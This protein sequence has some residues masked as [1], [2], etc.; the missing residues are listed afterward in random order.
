MAKYVELS[1]LAK[2][3]SK[4]EL[5]S[6]LNNHNGVNGNLIIN[7]IEKNKVVLEIKDYFINEI[8]DDLEDAA[9]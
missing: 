8:V 9:C 6:I 1:V 5:L 4:E 3:D 7:T 2:Y